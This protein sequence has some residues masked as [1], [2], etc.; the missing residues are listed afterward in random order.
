[1]PS[2]VAVPFTT[3]DTIGASFV[4]VRFTVTFVLVPS[5]EVTSKVSV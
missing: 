2:S 5:A 1:V 4:P 3:P